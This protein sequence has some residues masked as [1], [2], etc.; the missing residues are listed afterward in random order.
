MSS[1]LGL[2]AAA[3]VFALSSWPG[4]ALA[5]SARP[6]IRLDDGEIFPYMPLIRFWE[7]ASD[8]AMGT[9]PNERAPGQIQKVPSVHVHGNVSRADAGIVERKLKAASEMLLA[10]TPLR[11][12]HG[13]DVR[14]SI[15]ISRDTSGQVQGSLRIAAYPI[16]LSDP[17]TRIVD[18]RYSTPGEGASLM[19]WYNARLHDQ[20]WDR[21]LLVGEYDG[22]RIQSVLV[23]YAGLVVR[24]NRPFMV[25]GRNGNVLNPAFFDTGRPAGDLQLLW[26]YP[27]SGYGDREAPTTPAA[28]VAAAGYMADWKEIERRMALVR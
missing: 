12:V 15:N 22:I 13:A 7:K 17:K 5:Q 8:K 20:S 26:F 19:V 25:P 18:G 21:V 23:G 2:G 28:R 24:S 4:A 10:Q 14:T 27:S 6:T 3:I 16:S 1:R 9:T 11:D